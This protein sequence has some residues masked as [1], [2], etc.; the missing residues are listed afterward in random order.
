[1][2][3]YVPPILEGTPLHKALVDSIDRTGIAVLYSGY[4]QRGAYVY[5]FYMGRDQEIFSR[6]TWF[7]QPVFDDPRQWSGIVRWTPTDTIQTPPVVDAL[8]EAAARQIGLSDTVRAVREPR[9]LTY[10]SMIVPL[11]SGGKAAA[12]LPPFRPGKRQFMVSAIRP[13]D[14]DTLSFYSGPGWTRSSSFPPEYASQVK[15]RIVFVS[16]I[17]TPVQMEWAEIIYIRVVGVL[18]RNEALREFEAFPLVSTC[19]VVI[20]SA[21]VCLRLQPGFAVAII[22]G[23]GVTL[24]GCSTVLLATHHVLFQAAYPCA[25]ALLSGGIFPR[26]RLADE[27]A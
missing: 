26:V 23:V 24:L 8:T 4:G 10:G 20:L 9:K 1:M 27:N 25:A 3:A 12:F 18:A 16:W 2:V 13:L 11:N 19:L 5:P 22:F 7:V 21:V 15:D 14:S 17:V 6:R